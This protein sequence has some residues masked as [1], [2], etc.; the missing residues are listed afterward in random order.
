MLRY[1]NQF[2]TSDGRFTWLP[3]PCDSVTIHGIYLW[4]VILFSPLGPQVALFLEGL[5]WV[6]PWILSMSLCIQDFENISILPLVWVRV[7]S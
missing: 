1:R 7:S 6:C 3:G 2:E 5:V 4:P